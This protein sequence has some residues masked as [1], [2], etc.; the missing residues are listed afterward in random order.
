MQ[1]RVSNLWLS[2]ALIEAANLAPLADTPQQRQDGFLDEATESPA[3]LRSTSQSHRRM[4]QHLATV[5]LLVGSAAFSYLAWSQ[6]EI[7][8]GG[9]APAPPPATVLEYPGIPNDTGTAT[10][11]TD[12]SSVNA[13]RVKNRQLQLHIAAL[14]EALNQEEALS[15]PGRTP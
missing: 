11:R 8:L 6:S 5:L 13:L 10:W 2:D 14:E 3:T 1:Q 4:W 9:K 15:Q 12:Q 7:K